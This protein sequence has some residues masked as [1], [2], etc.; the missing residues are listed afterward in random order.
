MSQGQKVIVAGTGVSGIAAAKLLWERGGEVVLYDANEALDAEELKGK[1]K[2]NAKV[3]VVLGELKRTD[4]VGVEMCIVSPG[5]P[6]DSAFVATIV[7]AKIPIWG[8]VELAYQFAKGKLAAIT[9]TNGKTT[10]TALTGEILKAHFENVFVV[11]HQ[12]TAM[13]QQSAT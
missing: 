7:D 9:G 12:Y 1:F 11:K 6:M 10:T 3:T 5:V 4:L 2:K 13:E 8:E